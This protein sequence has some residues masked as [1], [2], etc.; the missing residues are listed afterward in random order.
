M[1]P[2]MA[3]ASNDLLN[4]PTDL[5]REV[6]KYF[7]LEDVQILDL[8]LV[9]HKLR[10]AYYSALSGIEILKLRNEYSGICIP[11]LSQRN[12]LVT[13]FETWSRFNI[14][15]RQYIIQSKPRLETLSLSKTPLSN[16]DLELIGM[17]PYLKSVSLICSKEITNQ[18]LE[19]FLRMNPQLE[20]LSI[21]FNSQFSNDLL[22]LTFE[23]CPHLT[24]LDI[25]HS[26]WVSD[27]SLDLIAQSSLGLKSLEISSTSISNERVIDFIENPPPSLRNLGIGNSPLETR[28]LVLSKLA[29]PALKDPDSKVQML[30]LQSFLENFKC[31]EDKELV[32]RVLSWPGLLSQF[33][34][35]LSNPDQNPVSIAVLF[36]LLIYSLHVSLVGV[37]KSFTR[38]CSSCLS[39][40]W[41]ISFT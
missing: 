15:I 31:I 39:T 12:I 13:E 36:I 20:K 4:L 16:N 26:K 41:G 2:P 19:N 37:A 28:I 25:S 30:G 40:L 22:Q 27:D 23:A 8:A 34:Y 33:I 24:H 17:C 38:N 1:S 29:L 21:G 14:Q 32:D 11:W 6:L 10:E 9:N 5:Y 3:C 18:G 7:F 35:F